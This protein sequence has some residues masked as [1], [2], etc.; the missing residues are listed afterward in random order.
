MV[1][2]I[3]QLIMAAI[4]LL[5]PPPP[6]RVVEF[7]V[8][9]KKRRRKRRLKGNIPRSRRLNETPKP[10]QHRTEQRECR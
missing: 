4:C 3:A 10:R 9:T 2:T 7:L 5:P 6:I 1:V 8:A